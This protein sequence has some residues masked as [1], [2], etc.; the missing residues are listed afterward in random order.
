MDIGIALCVSVATNGFGC[1]VDRP[2]RAWRFDLFRMGV[3]GERVGTARNNQTGH[4]PVSPGAITEAE[5]SGPASWPR[6]T[7]LSLGTKKA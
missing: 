7:V 4:V 3:L 6:K 5:V 2:E 1:A